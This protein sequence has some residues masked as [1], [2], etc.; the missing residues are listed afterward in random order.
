KEATGTFLGPASMGITVAQEALK[1]AG[2][3]GRT[4]AAEIL[5]KDPDPYALTLL[6][7]ALGDK[8]W[9]VRAAVAK[10]LGN[11][12]NR[13]TIPKLR[14]LLTDDRHAVRYLAAA[15]IVKLSLDRTEQR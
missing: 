6:E 9:A 15:S 5:G 8:S 11:R 10:A 3:P 1:D 13:D 4:A 7:W 12:G 2:V 14:P